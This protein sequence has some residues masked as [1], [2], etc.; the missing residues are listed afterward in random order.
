MIWVSAEN[1]GEE[2]NGESSE[3]QRWRVEKGVSGCES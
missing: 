1:V 2:E 3:K